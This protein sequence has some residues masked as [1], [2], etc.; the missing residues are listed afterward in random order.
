MANGRKIALFADGTGNARTAQFRTNVWKLYD[1]LE[2]SPDSGQIGFY[3]DGVGTSTFAPLKVLGGVFGVGLARN[4]RQL[5][6]HLCRYYQ[7]PDDEIFIFGFSRGAFTARILAGLIAYAGVKHITDEA[8]LARWVDQAYRANRWRIVQ[9]Q[10]GF[11]RR[12]L[13]EA[14]GRVRDLPRRGGPFAPSDVRPDIRLV[15]VWDTVAAYGGPIVEMVRGFDRWVWPLSMPDYMLSPKVVA[16]R[17]ALSLDEEREA[18]LP[19]PW[20]ERGSRNPERIRQV[21]FAG[22]HSDVG[23]GYADDALSGIPLAWMLSEAKEAGLK[24]KVAAETAITVSA[25]AWGPMHDSRSGVG[26]AYRYQPRSIN[27][28]MGLTPNSPLRDP[29]SGN[30]P[31][32][33]QAVVHTSV[34]SRIKDPDGYAPIVLPTTFVDEAG[35]GHQL[36]SARREEIWAL[37]RRRRTLQWALLASCAAAALSPLLPK[38]SLVAFVDQGLSIPFGAALAMVPLLPA[39]LKAAYAGTGTWLLACVALGTLWLRAG[40]RTRI[41]I[42]TASARMWAARTAPAKGAFAAAAPSRTGVLLDL[43]RRWQ[44]LLKWRIA[45]AAFGISFY[46]L[47]AFAVLTAVAQT[48]LLARE[49]DERLCATGGPTGAEFATS[50]PCHAIGRAVRGGRSYRVTFRVTQAWT[51]EGIPASPAGFTPVEAFAARWAS[52][53]QARAIQAFAALLLGTSIRREPPARWFAPVI[54]VRAR[55]SPWLYKIPLAAT[56]DEVGVFHARF[57]SPATGDT[58]VYVNDAI[59]PGA[60][61]R[62]YYANN[63]GAAHME[64]ERHD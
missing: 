30:E 43:H 47:V 1:A 38:P 16:A 59:A 33:Q 18:F 14:I 52:G 27:A 8:E 46:A 41:A 39:W 36:P 3:H 23:G 25:N 24:F 42:N 64:I 26:A 56:E 11:V 9:G 7:S 49:A 63:E 45:P 44:R 58:F 62:R 31:L 57:T 4:V 37:V 55:G 20:D 22:V 2:D 32:I 51:D 29:A 15:G 48:S 60:D 12:P 13:F 34:L 6:S 53:R 28:L 21:W 5:Y 54:A 10:I 17:H 35:S 19:L 40:D 61:A 50:E